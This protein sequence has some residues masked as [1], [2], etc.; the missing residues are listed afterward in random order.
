MEFYKF[1]C[2]NCGSTECEKVDDETYKCA[3]CG[4]VQKIFFEQKKQKED[5][6]SKDEDL[7]NSQKSSGFEKVQKGIDNSFKFYDKHKLLITMLVTIVFGW[8]GVQKFLKGQII[9][10]LV[11][12]FTLGLFYVGWIIDICDS[13]KQYKKTID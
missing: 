5:E 8:C 2:E 12:L 13:V 1:K 11:Y 4:K 6:N 9:L 7:N 3:F 10:G